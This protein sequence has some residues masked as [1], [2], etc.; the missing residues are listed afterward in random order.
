MQYLLLV[1]QDYDW[2]I[3]HFYKLSLQDQ[4]SKL[5][6]SNPRL[7]CNLTNQRF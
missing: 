1:L 5:I 2:Y 7:P 3:S 4:Q 6:L